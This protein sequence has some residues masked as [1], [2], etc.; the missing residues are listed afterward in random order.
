MLMI[1]EHLLDPLCFHS[2]FAVP[3]VHP[4]VH[5]L[6]FPPSFSAFCWL[7]VPGFYI[8]CHSFAARKLLDFLLDCWILLLFSSWFLCPETVLSLISSLSIMFF[9]C[10]VPFGSTSTTLKHNIWLKFLDW[11]ALG[12]F[13]HNI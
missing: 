8:S 3:I 12:K 10:L 6:R 2:V 7:Y 4:L 13:V 9:L 1:C 5:C 11:L